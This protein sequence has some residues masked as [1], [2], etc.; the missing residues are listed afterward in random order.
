MGVKLRELLPDELPP[1]PPPPLV[2]GSKVIAQ[3]VKRLRRHEDD[4]VFLK[5]I[6]RLVREVELVAVDARRSRRA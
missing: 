1:A 5:R 3:I 2:G 6:E 4:Q